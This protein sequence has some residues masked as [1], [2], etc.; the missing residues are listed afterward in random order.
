MQRLCTLQMFAD[1]ASD[2]AVE[3]QRCAVALGDGVGAVRVHHQI[4]WLAKFD[5]LIHETFG[6]LVV[7]VVVAG[8]MDDEESA[9]MA[10]IA[11]SVLDGQ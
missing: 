9:C 4:E 10:I 2:Q 6:A 5:Q 11:L 8:S 1:V 7:N 3:V